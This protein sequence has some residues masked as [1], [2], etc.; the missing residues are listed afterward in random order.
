MSEYLK[1]L[2]AFKHYPRAFQANYCRHNAN[3]VAE[4]ASRGHITC[5]DA[6]GRSLGVWEITAQGT[7]FLNQNG[8]CK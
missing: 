1:L 7:K 3:L 4:A 6:K 2:S 8:G 5:L